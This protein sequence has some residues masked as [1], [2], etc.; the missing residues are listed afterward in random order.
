[1]TVLSA[2]A[3]AVTTGRRETRGPATVHRTG[4]VLA[5]ADAAAAAVVVL[6]A[7]LVPDAI[8]RAGPAFLFVPLWVAAVATTGDYQ[9]PGHLAARGRR[10]AV[11]AL[12]LPTATLLTAEAIGYPVSA[13][14]VTTVC[15]A[16]AGLG[17][18]ARGALALAARS[19][20]RLSGVTHR[21]VLA[22]TADALPGLV[23]RL[24]QSR[25]QRFV[26]VGA[27]VA[28]GEAGDRPPLAGIPVVSGIA[29]CVPT[30]RVSGADAV[31][32]APDP[33]IPAADL[34]RLCW[35][36]EDAG[37]A[38][39]V[40]AGLFSSPA[41]RIHLDVG[42][43]L[44]L[45]HVGAPRRLGPSHLVKHLV[46]R[47]VATVALLLLAP[48]LLVLA[49][50]VRLDSP[51]PAF[52]RQTRIGRADA[53]FT[54]WKL[55][56]MSCDAADAVPGLLDLNEA[57]GPLFKIHQDPRITRVGRWLRRTSLDELPQLIN[58]ALGHMSLVGPRPALPAEV[59]AYLPDDRH[60]LV[61]RPGM[62][63]L[64]QV[65][66]RSD[67]SWEDAVRLD[68]QYVDNWSLLLDARILLRTAGAVVSGRGAY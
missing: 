13:G 7:V 12:V 55:R 3:T 10:L 42:E 39:F 18:L 36:L 49:A 50:A 26:V 63:G 47:A 27:C 35:C 41:G 20:V 5:L 14:V 51:G 38:I 60:R 53:P 67:L 17:G 32:L 24:H 62:T 19:G 11:A 45:L 48:V 40:W 29:A 58:V 44:P 4:R 21:V 16:S 65:S 66:G 43:R 31:I 52:F 2:R 1:M 34:Q 15:V 23:E 68:Q 57:A 37:V 6:V 61:V 28:A 64:W 22:G 8:S 56:T 33:A 46:D 30:A 59:A 9:L 54:M 25:T